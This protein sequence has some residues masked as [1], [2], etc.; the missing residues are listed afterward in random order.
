LRPGAP[1]FSAVAKAADGRDPEPAAPPPGMALHQAMPPPLTRLLAAGVLT[2]LAML[3]APVRADVS[4]Q[5]LELLEVKEGWLDSQRLLQL[6][7]WLTLGL[8]YTAEPMANPLGGERFQAAWVG[9]TSLALSVGTGLARPITQWREQD[10]WTLSTTLTHTGG[11]PDFSSRIGARFP[12]QQVAYPDGLLL[13]EASV[14]RSSG[15]G[16]LA[17][18]AGIVPLNPAFVTAPV[19][20]FYVHSAFNNTLNLSIDGLPINPYASLGGIVSLRPH[21][22]LTLRYGWFDLSSTEPLARWL[23]SPAP[24]NSSPGGSAQLLQLSWQP[25]GLAPAA[26]KPLQGC[27]SAAGVVRR[28]GACSQPVAVQNQLPG[29]L[30]SLGGYSTSRQAGGIYGS[31]TW[32]SG[33]PLGLDERLWIGGAWTP[34]DGG[35]FGPAFLA[36][37]LVVQGPLPGRPLDVLVLGAGRASLN[38][39]LTAA[40]PSVYEGM[41]ELGY[42]LQLNRSLALQPSLQWIVNPSGADRPVPG[43]LAAGLQLTFSF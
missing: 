15:T 35:S 19:F 5:Q 25:A 2:A 4:T 37:G 41:V 40:W 32:R 9:Q 30:F 23:G 11:N 8:T 14:M 29:A 38:P 20:D 42:Q 31:A 21:P 1:A 17:V 7:D 34:N 43:I 26:D 6:P 16:W 10:H 33:L 18:R 28:R 39:S 12:L 36:G 22:E 3:P 13:S 24:F 27:R